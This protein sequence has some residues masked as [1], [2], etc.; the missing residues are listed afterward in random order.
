MSVLWKR[1]NKKGQK[2]SILNCIYVLQ[3]RKNQKGLLSINFLWKRLNQ[4]V[5]IKVSIQSKLNRQRMNQMMK[6]HRLHI[7]HSSMRRAI[8]T[9]FGAVKHY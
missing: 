9:Y 7:T 3:R 2:R 5:F 6:N 8:L 4:K 1:E